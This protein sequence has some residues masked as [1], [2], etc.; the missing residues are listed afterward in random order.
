V[1]G[2]SLFGDIL[3]LTD[4][5]TGKWLHACVY[6]ADDIVYTKNGDDIIRPWILIKYG[7]LVARQ[8]NA[9]EVKVQSWRLRP[10]S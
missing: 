1:Q 6:I 4:P 10:D 3:V 7:D 5:Q 8:V 2:P 9:G